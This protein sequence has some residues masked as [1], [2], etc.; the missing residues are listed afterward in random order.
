MTPATFIFLIIIICSSI[1]IFKYV[2]SVHIPE[3][4]I[5]PVPPVMVLTYPPSSLPAVSL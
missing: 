4:N 2:L 1:K 3:I 5:Y